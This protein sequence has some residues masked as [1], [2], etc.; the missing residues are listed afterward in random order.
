L[1]P[2]PWRGFL[3]RWAHRAAK[4]QR[5]DHTP[6]GIII[7]A[8]AALM[9]LHDFGHD[10]KAETGSGGARPLST[11]KPLEHLNTASISHFFTCRAIVINSSP[12]RKSKENAS[13]VLGH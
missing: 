10:C 8:D 12:S 9:R 11:P 5:E 4:V 2:P 13:L 7:D 3:F 6:A 1:A